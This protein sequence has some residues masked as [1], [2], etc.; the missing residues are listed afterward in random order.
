MKRPLGGD[1]VSNAPATPPGRQ[2]VVVREGPSKKRPIVIDAAVGIIGLLLLLGSVVLVDVLPEDPVIVPQYKAVFEGGIGSPNNGIIDLDANAPVS[3]QTRYGAAGD[4]LIWRFQ[5]SETNIYE[6]SVDLFLSDDHKASLPD[7]F[8][9]FLTSPNGTETA[10]AAQQGFLETVPTVPNPQGAADGAVVPEY[11][12]DDPDAV[13]VSTIVF[14]VNAQPTDY[15]FTTEDLLGEPRDFELF[16]IEAALEAKETIADTIGEWQLRVHILEAGDCPEADPAGFAVQ[17]PLEC[18]L[19][20]AY[21]RNQADPS[22][23][24]PNQDAAVDPGNPVRLAKVTYLRFD[25]AVEES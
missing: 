18:R 10:Y 24:D 5:F 20:T 4:D 11:Y 15:F 1:G 22:G 21:E 9:V 2:V 23:A 8:Q 25:M 13:G 16:E 12:I 14:R 3:A 17:R 19:Q 7:R 6:I